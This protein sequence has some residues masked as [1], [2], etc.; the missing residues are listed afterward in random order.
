MQVLSKEESGLRS[1]PSS[2][3]SQEAVK[4]CLT[5]RKYLDRYIQSFQ[6][7]TEYWLMRF[8]Y[9][10]DCIWSLDSRREQDLTLI[11]DIYTTGMSECPSWKVALRCV[12]D[13]EEFMDDNCL[14]AVME[15]ALEVCGKDITAGGLLWMKRLEFEADHLEDRISRESLATADVQVAVEAAKPFFEVLGRLLS[16]PTVIIE[17]ALATMETVCN[18]AFGTED[19]MMVAADAFQL[20]DLSSKAALSLQERGLLADLESEIASLEDPVEEDEDDKRTTGSQLTSM[21]EIWLDYAKYEVERDSLAR[22][23]RIYQRAVICVH[24]RAL[25]ATASEGVAT[26]EAL[27][28]V[29]SLWL[30]YVKHVMSDIRVFQ[31]VSKLAIKAC[32]YSRDLWEMHFLSLERN[33]PVDLERLWLSHST[34]LQSRLSS[35]EDYSAILTAFP[36]A[37][38]RLIRGQGHREDAYEEPPRKRSRGFGEASLG[39]GLTSSAALPEG[40][41]KIAKEAKGQSKEWLL[42]CYPDW[43]DIWVA[44]ALAWT[45]LPV[46][47]AEAKETITT[48]IDRF[49]TTRH[50]GSLIEQLRKVD[51]AAS[52]LVLDRAVQEH[53]LGVLSADR[54]P[55]TVASLIASLDLRES[56]DR[57]HGNTEDYVACLHATAQVREKCKAHLE[58]ASSVTGDGGRTSQETEAKTKKVKDGKGGKKKKNTKKETVESPME[59][60]QDNSREGDEDD[61]GNYS[62]PSNTLRLRNLP[63]EATEAEIEALLQHKAKIRLSHAYSGR[64]KGVA[65]AA[66]DEL[67]HCRMVAEGEK[68]ELRGRPIHAEMVSKSSLERLLRQWAAPQP[69]T[70]NISGLPALYKEAHALTLFSHCGDI[71]EIS[72]FRVPGDKFDGRSGLKYNLPM[73]LGV[74][75]L[76][77]SISSKLPLA[78][79]LGLAFRCPFASSLWCPWRIHQLCP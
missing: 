20:E 5:L 61:E 41:E 38:A 24:D 72:L 1:F 4:E 35:A 67:N 12:E 76:L 14:L 53:V 66:F 64:S 70:V 21:V 71:V 25:L 73:S 27:P 33:D 13:A 40:W 68:L 31:H 43:D 63:F 57:L 50:I 15:E 22:A 3:T 75:K 46:C 26:P 8:A 36:A 17:R 39:L 44:W 58:L 74:R 77:I 16:Q 79:R 55:H 56:L 19:R 52:R 62:E 11:R 78:T 10:K 45:A 34:A 47:N 49:P 29:T 9:E 69:T 23:T 65:Y 37:L 59:V 2:K 51:M 18:M 6:T 54:T 7:S 28:A 30:S 60:K 48:V 42:R 32:F